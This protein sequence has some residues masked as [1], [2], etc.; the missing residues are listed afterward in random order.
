[1]NESENE[2]S[3]KVRFTVSVTA[4]DNGGISTVMSQPEW[5]DAAETSGGQGVSR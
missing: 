3:A 4:V 5:G 1:M 2:G